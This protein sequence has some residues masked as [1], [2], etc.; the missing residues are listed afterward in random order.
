MNPD[1][2][3]GSSKKPHTYTQEEALSMR[4]EIWELEN[5]LHSESEKAEKVKSKLDVALQIM[6]KEQLIEFINKTLYVDE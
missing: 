4:N 1:G 5:K 3:G 6:S 2:I